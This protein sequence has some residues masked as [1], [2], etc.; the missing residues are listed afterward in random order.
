M[1]TSEDSDTIDPFTVTHISGEYPEH[2][3]F[4]QA[5][6]IADATPLDNGLRVTLLDVANETFDLQLE[7]QRTTREQIANISYTITRIEGR[8][9]YQGTFRAK[10]MLVGTDEDEQKI[11]IRLDDKANLDFW[12]EIDIQKTVR[13]E[14]VGIIEEMYSEI[15]SV[16]ESPWHSVLQVNWDPELLKP[17]FTGDSGI[18]VS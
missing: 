12:L 17:N 9:P 6:F 3:D 5:Q 10:N 15:T 1:E 16:S 18:S 2:G 8:Y 7:L 13:D 11:T 4:K 14:I